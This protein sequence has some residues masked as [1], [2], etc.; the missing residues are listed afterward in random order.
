M[1]QYK[2]NEELL[3]YLESKNVT[4]KNR[5]LASKKIRKIY[6]LFCN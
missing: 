1:K 6:L 5:K 3:D 4:I 2:T